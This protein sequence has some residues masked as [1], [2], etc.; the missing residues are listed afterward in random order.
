LICVLAFA[1]R[2]SPGLCAKGSA[3]AKGRVKQ[4]VMAA[5]LPA[6]EIA[7]VRQPCRTMAQHRRKIFHIGFDT[8]HDRSK[9]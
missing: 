3:T 9:L 1:A 4:G 8:C 5:M 7:M 2:S 6:P